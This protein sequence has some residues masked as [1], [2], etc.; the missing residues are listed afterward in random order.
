MSADSPPPRGIESTEDLVERLAGL[1][2]PSTVILCVGDEMRGDDGAGPAVAEK[3]CGLV[4]WTVID[5]QNAPENFLMKVAA[6]E[7]EGVVLVDAL[8]FGGRPGA[9]RLVQ[10]GELTG[11]GPSTH[12]PAPLTFF[13]A[14]TT[15]RPCRCSVLGIQPL[16]TELD[17]PISEPVKE[18]IN[19]VVRAFRSLAQTRSRTT[20]HEQSDSE[21]GSFG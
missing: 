5:A 3:L 11:L 15:M 10:P 9:V 20:G 13:E 14:L 4:P 16:N 2:A 7:P 1:L 21:A 17:S 6:A 12:G 19:L 18:G 8:H